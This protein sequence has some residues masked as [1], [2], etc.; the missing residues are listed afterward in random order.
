M[1]PQRLLQHE[2]KM[3]ALTFYC[4]ER[5]RDNATYTISCSNDLCNSLL[6]YR[7]I[8]KW[9][10]KP[11]R[12]NISSFFSACLLS[13][14]WQTCSSQKNSF[15]RTHLSP[16]LNRGN[17]KMDLALVLFFA[18]SAAFFLRISPNFSV[19]THSLALPASSKP[20]KVALVRCKDI[21][22]SKRIQ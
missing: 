14:W 21:T 18:A 15:E 4:Q 13:S 11:R 3:K 17:L 19:T 2:I 5:S 22:F 16:I 1:K 8:R 6:Q 9:K 10:W 12:S 7:H 20:I